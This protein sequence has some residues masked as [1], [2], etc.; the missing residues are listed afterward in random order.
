[1]AYTERS[2]YDGHMNQKQSL[3]FHSCVQSLLDLGDHRVWSLVVSVFGDLARKRGDVISGRTLSALLD[4]MGVRPEA[5][6]VAL[7]RLRRDGWLIS[8][9]SGRN[10]VHRLSDFGF[11]QSNQASTRIYAAA[12][13]HDANWHVTVLP[14]MQWSELPEEQRQ[15]IA[16]THVQVAS[17]IYLGNGP[18][19][20]AL[21]GQFTLSGSSPTVPDWLRAQIGPDDLATA[22][23]ALLRVLKQL[24]GF[25]SS[26]K[27][28][29]PLPSAI[30]RSLLVHNWRRIVLKHPELPAKFF[31]DDWPGTECRQR[32]VGLLAQL[33]RPS[34]RILAELAP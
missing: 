23:S 26:A 6:R 2:V 20:Q 18:V 15:Q 8:E 31:P 11:E 9:K 29:D 33:D 3:D 19:P 5:M 30:L 21:A 12:V 22:Y 32:V 16:Q 27:P 28:L 4:P 17:H 25:L 24:D 10:S 13:D 14:A 34:P 7:H 1:M